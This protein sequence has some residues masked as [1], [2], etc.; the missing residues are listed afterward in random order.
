MVS[1]LVTFAHRARAANFGASL[2]KRGAVRGEEGILASLSDKNTRIV[3]YILLL[4]LSFLTYT[5][6][7]TS[8]ITFVITQYITTFKIPVM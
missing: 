4:L 6:V 1:D 2:L 7:S 3:T 5:N 8:V